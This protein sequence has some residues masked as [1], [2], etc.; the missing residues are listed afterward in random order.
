MRH[1]DQLQWWSD[2]DDTILAC[3]DSGRIL[4]PGEIAQKL[5]VSE[6]AAG[7]FLALL[8]LHDKVRILTVAS[9]PPA[10]R[11]KV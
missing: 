6:S 5:G 2:V 8:A 4:S 1:L 7:S 11:T 9:V 10:L 3:L